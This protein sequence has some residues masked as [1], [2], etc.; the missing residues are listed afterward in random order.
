MNLLSGGLSRVGW[1]IALFPLFLLIFLLRLLLCGYNGWLGFVC[2][3]I[4]NVVF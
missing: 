2:C 3:F 4:V 1:C